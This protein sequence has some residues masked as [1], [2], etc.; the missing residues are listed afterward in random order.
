[1]ISM[2]DVAVKAGV[3]KATVSRVLNGKNPVSPKAR[4]KV[5]TACKS[6]NYRMNANIQDLI[7]KSRNGF[8]RNLAFVMV[9]VSFSDPA[10]SPLVD[11]LAEEVGRLHYQ[12]S[13][14]KLTG[15]EKTIYDF[16]P[17]LRDIRADGLLV[18]GIVTAEILNL[19][20]EMQIPIVVIGNYDPEI[21][22]GVSCVFSDQEKWFRK[23]IGDMIAAGCRKFAFVNEP[24]QNFYIR[25]NFTIWE[26]I[27][28]DYSLKLD[29]DLIFW[30]TR[31]FSG[32]IST[33]QPVFMQKSIPF[34]GIIAT[35]FRLAQEISHLICA[36]FGFRKEYPVKLGTL[37]QNSALN[38]PV[39]IFYAQL[40]Q[41][42]QCQAAMRQLIGLMD[43]S[44]VPTI[45]TV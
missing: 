35:D 43:N 34:D 15:Q 21:L 37:Q 5:L 28:K 44:G 22:N 25:Q 14:V 6:L 13:L 36:R 42:K 8:T 45:V 39:T 7:L 17:L 32:I 3:S 24:P 26:K 4:K 41:R 18:S 10:Y 9:D 19:L 20:R 1:M 11:T 30:G 38:L 31:K 27:L 29:P 16:P 33:L 2:D 12:L 40:E 23:L